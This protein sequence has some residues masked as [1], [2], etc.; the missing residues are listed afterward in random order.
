MVVNYAPP[1]SGG[2]TLQ[3]SVYVCVHKYMVATRW[4][5]RDP[6]VYVRVCIFK[7]IVLTRASLFYFSGLAVPGACELQNRRGVVVTQCMPIYV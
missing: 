6:Y 3:M 5:A 2:H 1:R 4:L 7:D